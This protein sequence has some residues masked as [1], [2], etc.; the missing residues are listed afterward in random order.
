M[1][2]FLYT[3]HTLNFIKLEGNLPFAFIEREGEL[4]DLL[5]ILQSQHCLRKLLAN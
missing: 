5:K 4:L 2:H 3:V 1:G